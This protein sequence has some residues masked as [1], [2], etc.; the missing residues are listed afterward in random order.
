MFRMAKK[1]SNTAM[2]V[3]TKTLMLVSITAAL[4][5]AETAYVGRTLKRDSSGL[6]V[7]M[8]PTISTPISVPFAV[9]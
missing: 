3:M 4:P 5:P 8:T 9:P 6:K 7:V 1:A 2:T